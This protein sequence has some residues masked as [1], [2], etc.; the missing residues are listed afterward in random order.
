MY[1]N[2]YQLKHLKYKRLYFQEKLIQAYCGGM[3]YK[4]ELTKD[5]II[6]C[7]ET[8]QRSC[9]AYYWDKENILSY[10]KK[11]R[12]TKEQKIDLGND[13]LMK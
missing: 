2:L 7:Y 4:K 12:T 9:D 3:C 8:I 13:L 1:F 6:N 10:E 11:S 5:L